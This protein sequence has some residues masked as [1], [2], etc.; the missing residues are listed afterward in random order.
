MVERLWPAST[1]VCIAP[2]P[3]L[4]REDTELVRGR[5]P[6][7]A[8]NDAVRMVPWAD[9]L[10]SSDQTW[11]PKMNGAPSFQGRK[12]AILPQPRKANNPFARWP[13]IQVLKNTGQDGLERSPDGLRTGKNSGYAAINLAVHFGA[14]RILLLGY[15]MKIGS[16][17]QTHFDGPRRG[18]PATNFPMFRAMFDT[19]PEPLK[20][21]GVTVLNCSRKSALECFPR[22][23][24]A[25][26]MAQPTDLAVSA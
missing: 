14:V 12:Y 15:D 7:I 18:T 9:V 11:F 25:H 17:G 8:I 22:V 19:L 6:V 3:S 13:E 23:P 20:L 10:Y 1:V 5:Y 21:A 16:N 26:A 24:L 4:V 2:G